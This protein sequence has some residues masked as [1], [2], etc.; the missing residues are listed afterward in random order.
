MAL[1]SK[2]TR[3][4]TVDGVDYRWRVSRNK[5]DPPKFAVVIVEGGN[6]GGGVAKFE[7]PYLILDTWLYFRDPEPRP[8]PALESITP[9]DVER[10]IRTALEAGWKPASSVDFSMRITISEG[11]PAV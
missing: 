8:G 4:I 10:Y 9:A 7:L 6:A 2:G 5:T 11:K 3:C 1:P